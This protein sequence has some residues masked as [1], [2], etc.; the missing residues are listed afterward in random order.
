MHPDYEGIVER[1]GGR[2]LTV[3]V[4]ERIRDEFL[5]IDMAFL[6]AAELTKETAIKTHHLAL[7][8]FTGPFS[9]VW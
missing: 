7:L 9:Y 1:V 3:V 4:D 2:P 8:R 6:R 5:V